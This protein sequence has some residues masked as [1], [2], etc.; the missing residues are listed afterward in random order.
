MGMELRLTSRAEADIA[1]AF[2]WYEERLP[3]LGVEFV[4]S[5]DV[6]IGLVHR[7]PQLF[8]KRHS[9][10]RLAMTLR[11][12]YAVYFIWDEAANLVSIRRVLHF[13]QNAPKY[14]DSD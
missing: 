12:P 14:L 6:T 1:A 3:G 9:I 5:V 10:H 2:D 11:F 13:S 7:S 4:R 8:R